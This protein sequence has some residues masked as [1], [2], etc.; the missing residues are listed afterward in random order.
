VYT[1]S[2]T[3]LQKLRD[4]ND[5]AAW[6]R[7]AKLYLPLLF[8]WARRL[9]L[10]GADPADLVHDVF[11]K[12]KEKLPGFSYD[13]DVGSFRNWLRRVCRNHWRDHQR[14]LANHLVQAEDAQLAAL[15]IDDDGL[16]Q[17]W[18]QDYYALLMHQMFSI[19]EEQFDSISRTI[20]TELVL[21]GRL[22]DELARKLG[23]TVQAIYSRKFRVLRRLREE[24][25]EFLDE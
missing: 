1:T 9:P 3:L 16:E 20:F 15:A 18:N 22:V 12:L 11:I 25:A 19:L 5:A 23:L 7:F 17:F 21:N 13:P 14:R 4:P 6:D 10:A 2:I 8:F 24:L